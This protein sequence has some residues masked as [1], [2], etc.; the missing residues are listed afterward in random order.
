MIWRF[1]QSPSHVSPNK[2]K[3]NIMFLG[4]AMKDKP[5]RHPQEGSMLK[6]GDLG[7]GG[8]RALGSDPIPLRS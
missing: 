6:W 3:I 7:L 1:Y 4:V 8:W 2:M 5:N